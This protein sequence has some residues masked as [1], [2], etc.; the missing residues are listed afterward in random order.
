MLAQLLQVSLALSVGSP[1]WHVLLVRVHPL[2]VQC[3]PV[4]KRTKIITSLLL[5]GV[6]SSPSNLMKRNPFHDTKSVP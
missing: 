1:Q 5:H 4:T 3:Q 2:V 6:R